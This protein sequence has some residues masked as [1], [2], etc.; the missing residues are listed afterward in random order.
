M[1]Y[2]VHNYINITKVTSVKT[3][4][5]QSFQNKQVNRTGYISK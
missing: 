4:I 2:T 5:L 3:F 1:I